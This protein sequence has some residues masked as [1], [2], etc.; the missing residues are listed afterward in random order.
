MLPVVRGESEEGKMSSSLY[1]EPCIEQ[2]NKSLCDPLK[3]IFA[4]K[5]WDHDGSLGGH[6]IQLN[7]ADVPYLNG[8]RDGT[9]NK[10]IKRDIETLL[11]AITEYRAVI[12]YIDG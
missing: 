7:D 4:R 2:D 6:P 11:E 5:Y 3:Y 12:I 1:W 10:D 8:V 9:S